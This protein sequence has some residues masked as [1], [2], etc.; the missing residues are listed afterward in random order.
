MKNSEEWEM[1]SGVMIY[2]VAV[3]TTFLLLWFLTFISNVSEN[4]VKLENAKILI[5]RSIND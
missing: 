1:M 5:K 3:V 2:I 4:N